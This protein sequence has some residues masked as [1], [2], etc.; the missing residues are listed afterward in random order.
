MLRSGAVLM[1]WKIT[2]ADLLPLPAQE[3]PALRDNGSVAVIAQLFL[4]V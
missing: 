1:L 3:H 2:D 4:M